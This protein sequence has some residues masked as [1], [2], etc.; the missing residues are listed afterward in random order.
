MMNEE[1]TLG[2]TAQ[3]KYFNQGKPLSV[4][5]FS[6]DG[7]QVPTACLQRLSLNWELKQ[8][9]GHLASVWIES[10]EAQQE[11]AEAAAGAG[12]AGGAHACRGPGGPQRAAA[13]DGCRGA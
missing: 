3:T 12:A 11:G 4:T 1:V 5:A 8:N 6:E 7:T 9:S 2:Q 10:A 13:E